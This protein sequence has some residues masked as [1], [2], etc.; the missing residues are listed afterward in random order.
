MKKISYILLMMIVLLFYGHD[1]SAQNTTASGPNKNTA[2]KK[3]KL[4]DN[5]LGSKL[6]PVK[7]QSVTGEI[8]YLERLRDRDGKPV[9][10]ERIGHAGPTCDGHY[11]DKFLVK[12]RD[13]KVCVEIYLDM[14]CNGY[15]EANPI[16]EFQIGTRVTSLQTSPGKKSVPP[17]KKPSPS[18]KTVPDKAHKSSSK[19]SKG[20]ANSQSQGTSK[21][22]STRKEPGNKSKT[23]PVQDKIPG[24][25]DVPDP[26]LP[27]KEKTSPKIT[28]P[29]QKTKPTTTSTAPKSTQGDIIPGFDDVPSGSTVLKKGTAALNQT[30]LSRTPILDPSP[31]QPAKKNDIHRFAAMINQSVNDSF[32]TLEK[33][34]S[35]NLLV[36]QDSH[37]I[38]D[39][40]QDLKELYHICAGSKDP[41]E[42]IE[43]ITQKILDPQAV[44]LIIT[45]TVQFE[46]QTGKYLVT[47]IVISKP[48][49][50]LFMSKVFDYKPKI[51]Q[52]KME[53]DFKKEILDMIKTE[54]PRV[55]SLQAAAPEKG[56]AK[57]KSQSSPPQDIYVSIIPFFDPGNLK[58]AKKKSLSELLEEVVIKE[59]EVVRNSNSQL[60]VNVSNHTIHDE[61]DSVKELNSILSELNLKD[62]DKA[63]KIINDL[64]TPNGIDYIFT[65]IYSKD[66]RNNIIIVR[67][68]VISKKERKIFSMNLIFQK[69]ELLCPEAQTKEIKLCESAGDNIGAAL[70]MLLGQSIK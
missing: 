3:L 64:M 42:K 34:L 29:P 2:V 14:Y 46:E 39:K 1:L 26:P 7:C 56:G 18:K 12:S 58:V 50:K 15:T 55:F 24:F 60:G 36:N 32:K 65:V 16:K 37:T 30:F 44:D 53:K 8:D 48:D 27:K 11:Y 59:V 4:L 63:D 25:D 70:R 22:K 10:Y 54:F 62:S 57:N 6:N 17:A 33:G 38:H 61:E 40:N 47:P 9:I 41:Q 13:G 23:Q 45:G 69:D 5:D 31:V 67:P 19:H 28:A 49:N 35:I 51:K 68:H 21:N 20:I 52:A 66:T 43:E